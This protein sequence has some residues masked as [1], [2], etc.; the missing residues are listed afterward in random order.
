MFLH[1]LELALR[2]LGRN[3]VISFLMVLALALGISASV[4]MVTVLHKLSGDPLPKRSAVLFH[5]QLDPRPVNLASE[6]L[7]LPDDLSWID[8]V[9]LFRFTDKFPR[10]VMSSNWLPTQRPGGSMSMMTT[11]GTTS[12][13]FEM[14]DVPFVYGTAWSAEDDYRHAQVVVLSNAL[15]QRLFGGAD[16]VGRELVIATKVF[17]VIGVI[18]DWNPKPH[19]YDINEGAFADS[20]AIYIPF[21]TWM[22]LPQDYGYGP[23]HCWGSNF[24]AGEHD[25]KA[26]NCTW[27]QFWVEL[28]SPAQ[29]AKYLNELKQYDSQQFQVGRFERKPIVRLRGLLD[30]LDYKRVIPVTVRMQTWIAFGVLLICIVNTMGL[31]V[32]K[33]RQKS[34]EIGLRR[35]LGATRTHVLTQCLIEAS[36]VGLAGGLAGLPLAWIGLWIVRQQP[37]SYAASAH[38]D[39]P[40][41]GIALLLAVLASLGAGAL[42]AWQASRL[43]PALQVKSL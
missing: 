22:N 1:Y 31:M 8:A 19:F 33:F 27:A 24:N 23:M 38:L 12:S 25:P 34:G 9:N 17:R 16:S 18:G 7:E 32:A 26:Q 6:G 30:W 3:K 10:V 41:L 11:E 13:F 15:N 35:A 5:P 2:S 42:P 29:V 40:M 37:V 28:D 14:F 20:A 43:P 39:L 21:F 4:T 36:V